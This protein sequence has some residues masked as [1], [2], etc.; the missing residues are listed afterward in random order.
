MLAV[1]FMCTRVPVSRV[2]LVADQWL[3]VGASSSPNREVQVTKTKG[4]NKKYE[5]L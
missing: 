1:L 5:G 3:Q 2:F 4:P